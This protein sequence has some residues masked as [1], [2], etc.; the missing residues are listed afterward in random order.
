VY[1]KPTDSAACGATWKMCTRERWDPDQPY[2]VVEKG[3]HTCLVRGRTHDM[4][5]RFYTPA[6]LII[7]SDLHDTL[8]YE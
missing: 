6:G 1:G 8:G 3:C 2:D 4:L 5:V 7:D